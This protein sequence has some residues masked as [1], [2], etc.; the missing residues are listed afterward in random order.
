M[1][2]LATVAFT[3]AWKGEKGLHWIY[4][5]LDAPAGFTLWPIYWIGVISFM[6]AVLNPNYA[7]RSRLNLARIVTLAQFGF[8]R[9]QSIENAADAKMAFLRSFRLGQRMAIA[10]KLLNEL[11]EAKICLLNSDRKRAY[12]TKLRKQEASRG[13]TREL[14][15][16]GFVFDRGQQRRR[17][18]RPA[19]QVGPID[20]DQLED[21]LE[22]VVCADLR[23]GHVAP[24]EKGLSGNISPLNTGTTQLAA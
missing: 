14:Q 17:P 18:C 2:M 4:Y 23:S 24:L 13:P 10:E 1:L 9:Q 21:G 19:T 12:D 11:A 3:P 15:R 8:V 5:A 20:H 22:E 6:T 16:G 7:I